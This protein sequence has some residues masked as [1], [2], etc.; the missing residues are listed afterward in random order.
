MTTTVPTWWVLEGDRTPDH[1]GDICSG[2]YPTAAE[3]AEHAHP[4]ALLQQKGTA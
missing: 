2:P 1:W 4:G 3:A